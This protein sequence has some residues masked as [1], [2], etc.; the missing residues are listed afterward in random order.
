VWQGKVGNAAVRVCLNSWEGE[1]GSGS[2]YYMSHLEPIALSQEEGKWIERA[3][4]A[5]A[6]AQWDFATLTATRAE[7][8][9]RQGARRVPFSLTPLKWDEDADMD[10]PCGSRAFHEP[11]LVAGEV[12]YANAVFEGLRYVKTSYKPPAHFKDDVSI[13]T[14][15]YDAEGEG[16][17]TINAT[18]SA[19]LPAGNWDDEYFGCIEANIAATGTDGEWEESFAPSLVSRAFLGVE[20]TSATYCGGAHPNYYTMPHTYDRRSG[21]EVDLFDWIG[22]AR[23]KDG[24]SSIPEALRKLVMARWPK[25]SE[26]ECREAAA[27]SDFW[28]IALKHTGLAFSPDFPHVLTACEEPVTVEWAALAPF[29]DAEG[30]AGLARLRAR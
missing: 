8:T 2:Y 1:P 21:Q 19:H 15:T 23:G 16:D 3:P 9:W 27:E 17:A 20:E 28:S 18:L 26:A 12:H 29:L 14:F 11:R 13:E 25:D 6:E 4:G 7:G 30:K 5:D 22:P 24:D 10:G